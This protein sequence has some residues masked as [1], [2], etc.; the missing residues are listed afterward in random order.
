MPP[1]PSKKQPTGQGPSDASEFVFDGTV[2]KTNATSMSNVAATEDSAIVRIDKVIQAPEVLRHAEGQEITVYTGGGPKLA[3]GQRATFHTQGLVF[4]E[5]IAVHAREYHEVASAPAALAPQAAADPVKNHAAKRAQER[6]AAADTVISGKV[7]NVR[8]PA[9]APTAA[10]A[11]AAAEAEPTGR[12]S[13]HEPL[14]QEAVISVE[15]VH[16]GDPG[17]DTVVV[18]FPNSTDVMWHQ[19]PKFHPG[20]EGVFMLH[21]NEPKAVAKPMAL[22]A[23]ATPAQASPYTALDPADFHPSS[24]LS[25]VADVVA[26]PNQQ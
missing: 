3:V 16:K 4:G 12:I 17:S 13:E 5:S 1:T 11:A 23:N 8:L 25:A 20:Q 21:K 24:D 22:G 9:G 18:Q 19:A 6:F 26:P 7:V 2:Q 14:W 15:K 10:H